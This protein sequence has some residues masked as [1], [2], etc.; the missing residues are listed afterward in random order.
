MFLIFIKV[1]I[2]LIKNVSLSKVQYQTVV[3]VSPSSHP[4]Q[5]GK[6]TV[7]LNLIIIYAKS[8]D[9]SEKMCFKELLIDT[10]K[11]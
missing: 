9:H 2:Y 6:G 8:H 7:N 1:F 11:V 10:I 5:P 4:L 3:S